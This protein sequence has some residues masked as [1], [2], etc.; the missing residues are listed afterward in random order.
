MAATGNQGASMAREVTVAVCRGCRRGRGCV[1]ACQP[2]DHCHSHQLSCGR[3]FPGPGVRAAGFSRPAV[4]PG[5]RVGRPPVGGSSAVCS[6][7][8]APARPWCPL[9]VGTEAQVPA[10][11]PAQGPGAPTQGPAPAGDGIVGTLTGAPLGS[12]LLSVPFCDLDARPR[13]CGIPP[14]LR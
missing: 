4:P 1:P 9:L 7:T 5:Q 8:R 11:A 12:A 14:A 10:T 2:T 3:F 13:G 6:V